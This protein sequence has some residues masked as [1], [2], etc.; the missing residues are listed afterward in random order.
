MDQE[1]PIFKSQSKF[2]FK[3]STSFDLHIGAQRLAL[4]LKE[5]DFVYQNIFKSLFSDL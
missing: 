1:F 4:I 5:E 3:I 2:A